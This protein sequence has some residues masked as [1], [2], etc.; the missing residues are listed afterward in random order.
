MKL[1]NRI[2]CKG[3]Y[4]INGLFLTAVMTVVTAFW[5]FLVIAQEPSAS[6]ILGRV[7]ENI[8]AD[9]RIATI[10]MTIHG[11]RASRTVRSKSW[12]RET[13]KSF[14]EYLSPP[15]EAGTKMLKI[16]DQ[17]WIYSP[18]TDRTIQISGHMLREPVMGSDLSYEDF[19]EDPVLSNIYK[20]EIE[21]EE[22]VSERECW[23]LY[24]TAK[25]DDVTYQSRRLWVDK[26]RFFP[27]KEEWY[28]SGGTLLKT[29]EVKEIG[30]EQGRWYPKR[31]LF[32][33]VLKRGDGTEVVVEEIEFDADIPDRVFSRAALRR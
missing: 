22:V 12:V 26:E 14:S 17:L 19:M 5:A 7:D 1:Q 28:G 11:R 3:S 24:L 29:L 10:S 6:E 20:P 33:D 16:D 23:I 4:G 31:A 13:D 8:T 30:Q 27:M 25:S 21:G 32:N 2:I 18:S 9:S 15:R